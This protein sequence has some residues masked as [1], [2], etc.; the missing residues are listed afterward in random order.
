MLK[1]HV[2]D[3]DL[4]FSVYQENHYE[5]KNKPNIS[6]FRHFYEDTLVK[7]VNDCTVLNDMYLFFK[8]IL[9]IFDFFRE[10]SNDSG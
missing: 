8:F 2:E 10:V 7:V 4:V 9:A 6:F 1:V 3:A 5:E